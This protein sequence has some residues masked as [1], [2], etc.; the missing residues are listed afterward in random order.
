MAKAV[1][2]PSSTPKTR[3]PHSVIHAIVTISKIPSPVLFLGHDENGIGLFHRR[4]EEYIDRCYAEEEYRKA[5]H[6]DILEIVSDV[7]RLAKPAKKLA[8]LMQNLS[9]H[10]KDYIQDY[11]GW[12]VPW[13]VKPADKAQFFTEFRNGLAMLSALEDMREILVPK[14]KG[15]APSKADFNDRYGPFYSFVRELVFAIESRGGRATVDK[16]SGTGTLI[17][18]LE[19]LQPYMPDECIPPRLFVKHGNRTGVCRLAEVKRK[20]SFRREL[21]RFIKQFSTA[22]S[23]PRSETKTG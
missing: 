1:C 23:Q 18:V 15:G 9:A 16:N 21:P 5:R 3:V 12:N 7:T 4:I 6:P 22:S 8:Q 20:T 13:A 2:G 19:K 11:F 14:S 17:E 10:E